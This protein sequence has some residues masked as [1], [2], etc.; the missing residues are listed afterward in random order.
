ML[1]KSIASSPSNY[2]NLLVF[3][4]NTSFIEIEIFSA[5]ISDGEFMENDLVVN[6][7][8]MTSKPEF[9]I[10]FR[11]FR[12][13]GIERRGL[14]TVSMVPNSK[15]RFSSL[16]TSCLASLTKVHTLQ[17]FFCFI[18]LPSILFRYS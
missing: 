7:F 12:F 10:V 1:F 8:L 3:Y 18:F 15:F 17:H 13:R 4:S 6:G 16:K 2:S 5:S 11:P 14:G 9:R